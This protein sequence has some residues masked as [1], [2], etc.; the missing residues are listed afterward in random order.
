MAS[1]AASGGYYV[2]A[3]ADTIIAE[4]GTI[5]GSIGVT[6]LNF[7]V[8]SMLGKLGIGTGSVSAGESGEFGNPFLPHREGD[9]AVFRSGIEYIYGRFVDV[10]AEGCSLDK[11]RVD[12]IGKGQIW[13]GSEAVDNGLVDALGGLEDAWTAIAEL[14]GSNVRYVD[15]VPSET[16]ARP[17]LSMLGSAAS[18][19]GV[20][21]V[22]K[23]PVSM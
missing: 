1:Y 18:V 4:P 23:G 17:L 8:V 22:S 20:G 14:V 15:Y 6:G 3:Y 12:E 7:S 21:A 2:S 9:S 5:T 19:L 13:L 16:P 10:V 11:A